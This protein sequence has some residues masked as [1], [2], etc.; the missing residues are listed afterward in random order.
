V[1]LDVEYLVCLVH[2][3]IGGLRGGL[4]GRMAFI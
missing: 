3:W 2:G 4:F 1:E